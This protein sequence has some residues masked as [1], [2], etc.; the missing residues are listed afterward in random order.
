MA[1]SA[2]A[3]TS[4]WN[5]YEITHILDLVLLK[6]NHPKRLNLILSFSFR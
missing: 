6:F 2:S 4:N 1:N 3:Y 5:D